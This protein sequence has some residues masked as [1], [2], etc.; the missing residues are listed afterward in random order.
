MKG[1][2]P[3]AWEGMEHALNRNPALGKRSE[4]PPG[5]AALLTA[6]PKREPPVARDLLAEGSV[7]TF[8]WRSM[9][10][11]QLGGET[12]DD[13]GLKRPIRRAC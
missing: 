3:L 11:Q 8:D 4:P 13:R 2:E 9:G 5:H 6:T 1:V 12:V 7:A 10:S